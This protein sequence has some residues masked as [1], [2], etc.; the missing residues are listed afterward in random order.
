MKRRAVY[1]LLC[2]CFCFSSLSLSSSAVDTF[3]FDSLPPIE[4]PDTPM[5]D[6]IDV[7][8]PYAPMLL[9]DQSQNWLGNMLTHDGF[10]FS[11]AVLKSDRFIYAENLPYGKDTLVLG[12]RN[13]IN[14]AIYL[15]YLN[16]LTTNIII[17]TWNSSNGR[18]AI[19]VSSLSPI[20][21]IGFGMAQGNVISFNGA[22]GLTD[23]GT[24]VPATDTRK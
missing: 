8:D 18:C 10:E 12:F 4:L 15:L 1:F 20:Y 14:T 6:L 5:Q 19:D 22:Y 21:R 11:E 17:Q 24:L 3:D 23:K 13:N 7:W 9:I 16:A 2:L